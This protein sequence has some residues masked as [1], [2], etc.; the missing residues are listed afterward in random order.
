MNK[1][2]I[3][4][5]VKNLNFLI[6]K[7]NKH[8]N[9]NDLMSHEIKLGIDAQNTIFNYYLDSKKKKKL[10]IKYEI[11]TYDE[12]NLIISLIRKIHLLNCHLCFRI[13]DENINSELFYLPANKLLIPKINDVILSIG[14]FFD[15][16]LTNDNYIIKKFDFE[17][18]NYI[19]IGL[20]FHNFLTISTFDFLV[21]NQRFYDINLSNNE[22]IL[23]QFS[24]EFNFNLSDNYSKIKFKKFQKFNLSLFVIVNINYE[25]ENEIE[26][27]IV[28]SIIS[29][30]NEFEQ[31]IN[32]YINK[33]ELNI[34]IQ[35]IISSL[36]T[37]HQITDNQEL[38]SNLEKIFEPNLCDD[39]TQIENRLYKNFLNYKK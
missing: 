11:F 6:S 23:N 3:Q 32:L 27:Q 8:F 29:L 21:F 1:N 18:E 16:K 12:L 36:E 24:Y 22:K 28:N 9:K 4:V 31:K 14:N 19:E 26:N 38:Y 25:I 20:I 35:T 30:K 13:I 2:N 34:S 37:L 10:C 33:C 39:N 7:V 5:I 15:K 17:S